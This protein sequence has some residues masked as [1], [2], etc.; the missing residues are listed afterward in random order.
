[1]AK[2][3]FLIE[4]M[5]RIQ[6]SINDITPDI[7]A[8]I[9]LVLYREFGWEHEEIND[10]F[11]KSQEIWTECV[12]TDINMVQMC[13]DETGIDVQRKVHEEYGTE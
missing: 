5:K 7:Y 1:M 9:A 13:L 12:Q 6:K 11:V 2:N 3:K 10:L 8:G 4:Q